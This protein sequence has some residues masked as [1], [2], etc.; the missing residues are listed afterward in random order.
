MLCIL[1]ALRSANH[2]FLD[3]P[4]GA[5]VVTGLALPWTRPGPGVAVCVCEAVSHLAT[6]ALEC[7]GRVLLAATLVARAG[8][9][10]LPARL[11]KSAG[12][13]PSFGGVYTATNKSS[14]T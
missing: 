8:G 1:T 5:L 6:G 3:W 9:S 7:C 4:I 11:T 2:G 14:G 12:E 13:P 10:D